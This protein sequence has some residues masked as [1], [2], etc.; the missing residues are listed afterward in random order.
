MGAKWSGSGVE[1]TRE[2]ALT[3]LTQAAMLLKTGFFHRAP[4]KGFGLSSAELGSMI[5]DVANFYREGAPMERTLEE[6]KALNRAIT[7]LDRDRV[8]RWS[9]FFKQNDIPLIL[10]GD[11]EAWKKHFEAQRRPHLEDLRWRWVDLPYDNGQGVYASVGVR[12]KPQYLLRFMLLTSYMNRVLGWSIPEIEEK[13][14]LGGGQWKFW[15]GGGGFGTWL[16]DRFEIGPDN[17]KK[18]CA[19]VNAHADEFFGGNNVWILVHNELARLRAGR[20]PGAS[21]ERYWISYRIW[22]TTD[23]TLPELQGDTLDEQ[24][25]TVRSWWEGE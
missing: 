6:S 17:V 11:P 5:E 19:W 18:L 9:T 21:Y 8:E 24:Q 22:G 2:T 7:D 14:G 1:I 20:E 4:N 23:G 12:K 25:P 3:V 15:E 16:L 13:I 10:T